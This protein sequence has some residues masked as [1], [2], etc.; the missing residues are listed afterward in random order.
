MLQ[1]RIK[2]LKPGVFNIA[3]FFTLE[4]L[5]LFAMELPVEIR[6]GFS[7]NEIDKGISHIT[8]ILILLKHLFP[9]ITLRS[10]GK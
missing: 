10:I 2:A 1:K 7:V 6:N 9:E 5:P 3:D 4:F 8:L